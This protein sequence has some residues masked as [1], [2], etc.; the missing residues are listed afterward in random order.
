MVLLHI[1]GSDVATGSGVGGISGCGCS[2]ISVESVG[3]PILRLL[4]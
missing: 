2:F 1:G 3:K 4:F